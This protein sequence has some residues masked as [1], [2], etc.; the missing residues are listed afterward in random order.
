MKRTLMLSAILLTLVGIWFFTRQ[1]NDSK[2]EALS[3]DRDF[4]IDDVNDIH[5]VSLDYQ[6]RPDVVLVKQ[7]N[8]SWLMNDS[9]EIWDATMKIFLNTCKDLKVDYTVPRKSLERIKQDFKERGINVKILDKKGQVLNQYTVGKN[10]PGEDGTIAMKPGAK[11]AFIV[12]IPYQVGTV[13]DRYIVKQDWKNRWIFREKLDD[14]KKVSVL[15]PSFPDRSFILEK[16]GRDEYNLSRPDNESVQSKPKTLKRGKAE[17]YLM[18]F[19]QIGIEAYENI[20]P[21]QDSIRGLEP[22][23][24]VNVDAKD[25]KKWIKLYPIN[26]TNGQVDTSPEF[27]NSG[28][29]FRF[30][31]DYS[32]GDFVLIQ[33]YTIGDAL[34]TY[35]YFLE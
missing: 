22:Y 6:D 31:G 13:R 18:N 23:A 35:S 12:G 8:G 10:L 9:M 5:S 19:E 1:S 20:H 17:A 34:R 3:Y 14:I 7:T 15:Y 29:L 21:K 2:M 33:H 16:V 4:G 26:H 27:V 25:G 28:Q 32:A 24:I 11:D 30:F